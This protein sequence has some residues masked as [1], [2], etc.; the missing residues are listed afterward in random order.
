M[1]MRK[2]S[3][4]GFDLTVNRERRG[5]GPTG[6]SQISS[7]R[8]SCASYQA[9]PFRRVPA[10]SDQNRPDVSALGLEGYLIWIYYEVLAEVLGSPVYP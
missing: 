4:H 9:G 8:M 7:H 2:A 10:T 1:K 5:S 6:Y 3:G